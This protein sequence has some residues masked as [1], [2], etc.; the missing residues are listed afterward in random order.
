M[1]IAAGMP[2]IALMERAGAAVADEAARMA[3]SARPNRDPL[4]PRRQW[5]RR[6][7]R[8]RGCSPSAAIASNSLCSARARRCAAIPR[9]RRRAIAGAVAAAGAFDPA[10]ADLVIDAL[11]GA[12]LRATSTASRAIASS[13]STPSPRAAGRCSP[14]TFPPASTARP[15]RFA[16]SRSRRARASPSSASSRAICCCRAA[17]LAGALAL[18]DIGIGA[19]RARRDRAARLRQRAADLARRACRG[20]RPRSHKYTRGS[21]LVLSGAGASHRR[22]AAGRARGAARRARGWSRSRARPT[23]SPSTPPIRPR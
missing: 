22:G 17:N 5:R 7:H 1:T 21:A 20:S 8:R 16:A 14:S 19:E 11:Y 2:G 10:G 6:I 12:G 4:R 13:A 23:R 9:W 3:R 18:A 15:A